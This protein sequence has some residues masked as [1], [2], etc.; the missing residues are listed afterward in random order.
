[1]ARR[2]TL[3]TPEIVRQRIKTSQLLNRLHKQVFDSDAPPMTMVQLKAATFLLS[4]VVGTA[5]DPQDLNING[6]MTY[7]FRD[8]THRPPQMTNGHHRSHIDR[9]EPES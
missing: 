1:M 9:S 3:W 2:K 6:N 5:T 7:V 8:P 4:R